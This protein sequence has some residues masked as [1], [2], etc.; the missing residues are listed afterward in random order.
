[1]FTKQ[2]VFTPIAKH[3]LSLKEK[4][5]PCYE[6]NTLLGV[7]VEHSIV[8]TKTTSIGEEMHKLI[9][10]LEEIFV[11]EDVKEIEKALR[12]IAVKHNCKMPS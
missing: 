7:V 12:N 8:T 5:V 9:S 2:E 6:T 11:L 3:L 10:D 4:L 1:M